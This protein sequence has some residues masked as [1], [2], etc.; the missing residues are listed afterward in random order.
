MSPAT[1]L[2]VVVHEQRARRLP[3][4]LKRP[5]PTR[6]MLDTRQLVNGLRLNTVCV[7][8]R[9]PNLTECWSRGTATFMI[10]GDR[11]TRRCHFCAVTTKRPL[12]PEEDE[13]ERVAEA[14]AHLKLRHVVITSVA[15]DDLPDEGAGH[16]ARCI[17]KTRAKL[18]YATIEVLV[19]DF[20]ARRELIKIV[21]AA[22]PEVYNHN[23]ETVASQ[24]RRV[25]PG[26]RYQRSLDVLRVVKEIDTGLKTKSGVMV[27]LGET[28]AELVQTMKDLRAVDCDLLTIGQYLRPS[29]RQVRVERFYPPAE[30]DEL[31]DLA[32]GLGFEGVASGPFVRSS[33][34]AE[35]LYADATLRSR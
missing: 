16:F 25:R 18:P 33:Y 17:A 22:R 26:A 31:A 12:P 24:Q 34:F 14:A 8:A 29:D 6:G 3:P 10:L 35:T 13:P 4:W 23:I 1:P 11:C 20:H 30:F 9:C 7:E 15:R 28:K 19:P 5:L 27:G 2:P 32:R 21:C